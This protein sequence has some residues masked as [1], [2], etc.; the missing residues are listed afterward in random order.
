MPDN[1]GDI[2]K[3]LPGKDAS[4]RVA[5][6]RRSDGHNEIRPERWYENVFED[7]VIWA[8]WTPV[9]SYRSGIFASVALAEAE[10]YADPW[11]RP[12]VGNAPAQRH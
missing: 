12:L 1:Q 4:T 3:M 8:G 6:V 10:A 11:V 5:I 7:E 2:A 9:L